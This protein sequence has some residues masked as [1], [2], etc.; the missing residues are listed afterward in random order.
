MPEI[1]DYK[2]GMKVA[3]GMI[4]RGMP[5]S[6]YHQLPW[7]GSSTA[8]A[9]IS[10]PDA[11]NKALIG[12]PSTRNMVMGTVF[13]AATPTGKV[14]DFCVVIDDARTKEGR[15]AK[16]KAEE[17]GEVWL[18]ASEF[19]TVTSMVNAAR[20]NPWVSK[21]LKSSDGEEEVSFFGELDGLKAK[22]RFDWSYGWTGDTVTAVDWKSTQNA[23]LGEFARSVLNFHYH[24]QEPWYRAV[25]NSCGVKVD[26]F[27]FVAV[28]NRPP[29][30]CGIYYL[31]DKSRA[32]GTQ[33]CRWALGS[34]KTHEK[35]GRWP[36]LPTD[37]IELELPR[38]GF[39]YTNGW[40]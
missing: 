40:E 32:E 28:E 34:M 26:R 24:V 17:E 12:I 10:D 27:Y 31:S 19:E 4:V 11:P 37:P 6:V 13:H 38:Y 30:N 5:D 21:W 23:S 3:P 35:A 15:A 36:G 1:I 9:L 29:H 20:A 18:S 22:C 16:A 7:W 8:K 25:A 14:R 33:A 39:K 2:P